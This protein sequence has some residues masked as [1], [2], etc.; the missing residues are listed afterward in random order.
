MHINHTYI[1]IVYI[2]T[3]IHTCMHAYIHTYTHT[4]LHTHI[5]IYIYVCSFVYTHI[6]IYIIYIYTYIYI[7]KHTP[8]TPQGERG[9]VPHPHHTTGGRGTVP[10]PH[11]TTGGR[12]T[13]LWLT[14]DHGGGGWNAGYIN[15]N[16]Y[17]YIYIFKNHIQ[18][19]S[20]CA[21]T[22]PRRITCRLPAVRLRWPNLR[23]PQRCQLHRHGARRCLMVPVWW[24]VYLPSY[25]C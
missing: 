24:D 5:Y 16:I 3:C 19:T 12:G 13:V 11:D 14:H 9:T 15:I 4:Y 6:Y 20:L 7:Y 21:E 2:H 17:V 8:T 10:H 22:R 18:S 25:L 23:S 1:Y